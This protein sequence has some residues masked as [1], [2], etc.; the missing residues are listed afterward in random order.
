MYR[1]I[2]S[3]A[4]LVEEDKDYLAELEVLHAALHKVRIIYIYVHMGVYLQIHLHTPPL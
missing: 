3:P 2:D 1:S 4:T